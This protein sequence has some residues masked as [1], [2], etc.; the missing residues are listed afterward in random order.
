MLLLL[1]CAFPL[2]TQN[3]S[4]FS[5]DMNGTPV[6]GA[7]VLITYQNVSSGMFGDATLLGKTGEDGA[8]SASISNRVPQGNSIDYFKV[9]A[10][11]NYWAGEE[12][13][14]DVD[15]ASSLSVNFTI[16]FS[17]ERIAVS[18]LSS[19][20]KPVQNATIY[21]LEANSKKTT[22]S[23]GTARFSLPTGVPFSG[24][25][26]Y[27]DINERFSDASVSVINGVKTAI[28]ILP[29]NASGAG[30]A[31][32]PHVLFSA[33]LIG[34]DR[35]PIA[36]QQVTF[37]FNGT[38]TTN[39][40]SESG[41]ASLLINQS[42]QLVVSV[43]KYDHEYRYYYDIAVK[44]LSSVQARNETV[45][46]RPLLNISRFYSVESSVNCY[47]LFANVTDPR[48]M[49]PLDISMAKSTRSA[50]LNSTLTI[51]M[52]VGLNDD[53]LYTSSVCIRAN[54]QAHVYASNKYESAQMGLNLTYRAPPPYVPKPVTTVA[55][56][57]PES[58]DILLSLIAFI[59]VII[60]L[61][62]F[63]MGRRYLAMVSRFI[64]E[65]LRLV[66]RILQR[67]RR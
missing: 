1:Q 64:I 13:T 5:Y 42:G 28:V 41:I 47:T 7:D 59:I 39:L 49:F 54:T 29:F 51:P 17:T 57:R 3:L 23:L 35:K 43:S 24:L 53:G 10:S 37:S 61:V 50:D 67:K 52:P 56:A 30:Y 58:E 62:A 55:P 9:K 8:F 4:V 15:P 63:I 31:G 16:P 20:S 45:V 65:Y 12:R 40:T 2:W 48:T 38:N 60:I 66:L 22:S 11:T 44:N 34:L 27:F 36:E 26:S 32:R 19:D 33:R 46:L 18:V 14:I 6:E 21:V 25:V